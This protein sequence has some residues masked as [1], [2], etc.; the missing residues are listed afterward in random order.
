MSPPIVPESAHSEEGMH[1]VAWALEELG[2]PVEAVGGTLLISLPEGDRAA[3]DGKPQIRLANAAEA[4]A[5]TDHE[6]LAW[7]GRF[8]QWLRG[9]LAQAGMALHARPLVQPMGVND[10]TAR[11]FPAYAVEKGQIHLAGCQLTDH[12]FLRLSFVAAGN[13]PSVRHIFVAP[14]GSAVSDELVPQLGLDELQPILKFPPRLEE[15]ALRALIAAGRRIA[16]KQSSTRD[17]QATAV[18]PLAVAVLWVRHA[19]GRLQFTVRSATATLPFSSWARLLKAEPFVGKESHVSSFRLAATDDDRIEAAEAIGVCQ[20]S[21]RR[22]LLQELV[23]CSVTG[24]Y[25]LP[26]FTENCPVSGLPALRGEFAICTRC[27]QRVSQAV[28]SDGVCEAC[29]GVAEVSR[30]DP[31]LQWIFGENP[32][33]D[34]WK[35]W[36]LAE[37]ETA[38]IAQASRLWKQLLVV[39]DKESLAIRRLAQRTRLSST[40]IDVKDAARDDLLK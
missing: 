28:L 14:D 9:R 27:R 35:Q 38:Y 24:L 37:T 17:P 4:G 32:G 5:A 36:Q 39:V 21:G 15:N 25:V 8:G 3:F 1:F 30:D 34:R 10:V 16:A 6:P 23:H 22:V 29:R 7:E 33:L 31:R 12:P 19:E 18:E 20:K 40:W 26:A 13:D 2:I 11:L